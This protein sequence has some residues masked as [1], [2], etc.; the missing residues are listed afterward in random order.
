M[1]GDYEISIAEERIAATYDTLRNALERGGGPKIERTSRFEQTMMLFAAVIVCERQAGENDGAHAVFRDADWHPFHAE[2]CNRLVDREIL[3]GVLKEAVYRMEFDS[4]FIGR[5][6]TQ[7]LEEAKS[8]LEHCDRL[9][10]TK[11]KDG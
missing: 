2:L 6:R 5:G 4:D 3:I 8:I 7:T 1:L 11:R 10:P 9:S